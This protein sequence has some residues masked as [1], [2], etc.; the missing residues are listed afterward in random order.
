VEGRASRGV[1]FPGDPL[2]FEVSAT[3]VDRETEITWTGGGDPPQG[4]G[5]RFVTSFSTGGSFVVTARV[6]AEVARFAVTV[7]ELDR[8]LTRAADFF[9]ASIDLTR[10]RVKG[11][12]AVWGPPGTGWTCNDVIRFKRPARADDFPTEATLIHELGH[13]WEHQTG[14]AQ[15][16]KGI[17]EQI[18]RVFGRD[19]YD[20]GGPEGL[21]A[22]TTLTSFSKEAQAQ[23]V[24]EFWRSHHGFDRDRLGVPFATV[25]YASDLERLVVGAGIGSRAQPH[26]SLAAGIDA[27]V[28]RVVNSITDLIG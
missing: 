14:Q 7:C 20:Y 5:P 6:G 10:V 21:R 18:G 19:P 9:G 12:R 16:L 24:T 26:H 15:L 13:V 23:I 28:A 2:A 1:A 17:F 3:S 4:S 27:V 25:D 22:A 8:W 11:A